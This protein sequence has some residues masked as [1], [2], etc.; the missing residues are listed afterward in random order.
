MV[1]DPPNP[2]A[3]GATRVLAP[4]MLMRCGRSVDVKD[5]ELLVLRHQLEV[6]RRKVER[7]KRRAPSST[8]A[9]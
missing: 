9:R 3:E 5:I 8:M 4:F 2:P 7:P 1:A 6:L